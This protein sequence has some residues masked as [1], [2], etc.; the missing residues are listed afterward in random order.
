MPVETKPRGARTGYAH[1]N[2]YARALEDCDRKISREHFISKALLQRLEPLTIEGTPW[3]VEK[4]TTNPNALASN[5]LCKR[6]NEALSRLDDKIVELYDALR[7]WH[8]DEEVGERFFDGE[9]I[10]RWA[11]KAMLGFVTSGNARGPAAGGKL[12]ARSVPD[13]YVRVLFGEEQLEDGCGLYLLDQWVP[14]EQ[15]TGGVSLAVV[16]SEDGPY[17]GMIAGIATSIANVSFVVT[18]TAQISSLTRYRPSEIQLGDKGALV[19]RW[20]G[21]NSGGGVYRLHGERV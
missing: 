8:Q 18:A 1:P 11:I 10:E 16:T 3:A 19:L 12:V 4:R 5:I 2:C 21:V 17:A 9:D 7:S 14:P 20:A 13:W 15:R 6:H